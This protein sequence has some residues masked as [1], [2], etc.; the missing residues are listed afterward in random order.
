M[1]SKDSPGFQGPGSSGA[2]GGSASRALGSVR[3]RASKSPAPGRGVS[4]VH[5]P[6]DD[7]SDEDSAGRSERVR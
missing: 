3:D 6:D 2:V 5:L 4:D 1:T 7:N